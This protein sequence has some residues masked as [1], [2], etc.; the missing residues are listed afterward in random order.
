MHFHYPL[1]ADGKLSY[2]TQSSI[3]LKAFMAAAEFGDL[4]SLYSAWR[5][6]K[7]YAVL[8]RKEHLFYRSC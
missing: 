6:A 3:F 1:E 2:E 5:P 7:M 4:T 8:Q